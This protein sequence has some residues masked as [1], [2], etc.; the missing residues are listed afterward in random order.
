MPRKKRKRGLSGLIALIGAIL[1]YF[2]WGL[3]GAIVL[4]IAGLIIEDYI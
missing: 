1:G 2:Y 3:P 4:G